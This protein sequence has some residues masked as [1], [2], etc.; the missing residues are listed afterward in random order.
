M[1]K[2]AG[3][4]AVVDDKVGVLRFR[5]WLKDVS[6]MV[7]RRFEVPS[8]LTLQ[9]LHGVLQVVMGWESIHLFMFVIQT[10]RYG[11]WETGARSFSVQLAE[12]KLRKGRR[13]LYEYDLNIPWEH[14]VRLEDCQPFDPGTRLPVCTGGDGRCP[15]ENCGGPK[16]WMW[17]QDNAL[18]AEMREDM[19]TAIGILKEAHDKTSFDAFDDP[20]RIEDLRDALDRIEARSKWLGSPFERRTVNARL[21]RDEHLALMHQQM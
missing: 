6:P 3:S 21:R 1:T 5:V 9:E 16:G 15:Q 13:F 20:E 19:L 14:E 10:A 18:G 11:S 2:V 17:R 12:L 4:S 7:W 8:T